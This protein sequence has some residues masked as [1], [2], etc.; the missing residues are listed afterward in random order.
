[1]TELE[2]IAYAKTY[3]EKLANG[4]NPLTGEVV[5]ESDLINNVRISR[6][7]FYVSDVLRQV[8]ERGGSSPR[9]AKA[10]KVPFEIDYQTRQNFSYSEHP[11]TISEI[12]KRINDLIAIPEMKKLSYKHISHW[13]VECGYIVLIPDEKGKMIR[14]PTDQGVRVGI[15][16]EQREG[17]QGVY[18]I[19][20][21]SKSA[22]KLIMEHLNEIA[23]LARA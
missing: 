21:Y 19:C 10:P 13:L 2:K 16:V 22:Q 20:F 18:S 4:I 3:V 9:R 8:V 23:Q 12:T 5:P 15:A 7:L 1:M 14:V 11:I 17:I 6:C